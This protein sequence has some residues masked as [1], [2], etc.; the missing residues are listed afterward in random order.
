MR[1]L[2]FLA[3]LLMAC[4]GEAAEVKAVDGDSLVIGERRIRLL[5]IDAPEY[6]QTCGDKDGYDYPC[7]QDSL[8]FMQELLAKGQVECK[9]VQKDIYKRDLSICYVNGEDINRKM[10]E[11]GR[12]VVY[13]TD[14]T[15]YLAAEESARVNKRG[16]WQGKFMKPEL[17]RILMK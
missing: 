1:I 2:V 3:G 13:R 8:R 7:G 12:A 11:N 6:S 15:E 16:V 17:Y 5:G 4:R 9:T 14:D 10:I